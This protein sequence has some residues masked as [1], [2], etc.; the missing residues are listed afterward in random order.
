MF[1]ICFPSYS[2]L[3]EALNKRNLITKDSNEVFNLPTISW[4][5]YL[6]GEYVIENEA[7]RK[8]MHH[9]I[10][11]RA[12]RML[13]DLLLIC[14]KMPHKDRIRIFREPTFWEKVSKPLVKELMN[15]TSVFT[16]EDEMELGHEQF[17]EIRNLSCGLQVYGVKYDFVKLIEDKQYRDRKKVQLRFAQSKS[18]LITNHDL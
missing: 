15:N 12:K 13:K 11:Q 16:P 7:S 17:E 10:R 14:Q 4:R 6:R 2:Y 5:E 18:G 3:G 9:D 1:F 8:K